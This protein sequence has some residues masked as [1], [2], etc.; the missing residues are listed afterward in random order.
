MKEDKTKIIF[1][2]KYFLA[3][4]KVVIVLFSPYKIFKKNF[5]KKAFF[6]TTSMLN[7]V[8][9]FKSLRKFLFF[10]TSTTCKDKK[11]VFSI[12]IFA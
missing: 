8:A 7:F 12:F 10:C 1:F 9:L 4:G 2:F 11:L 6:A 3:V 5:K